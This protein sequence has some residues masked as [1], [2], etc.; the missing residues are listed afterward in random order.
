MVPSVERPRLAKS[1]PLHVDADVTKG[2]FEDSRPMQ[3]LSCRRAA[4]PE[5][6]AGSASTTEAS[7]AALAQ[8]SLEEDPSPFHL[9]TH[10]PYP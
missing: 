9:L 5:G 6:S 4:S 8:F 7:S 2:R 1:V 3:R 10:S